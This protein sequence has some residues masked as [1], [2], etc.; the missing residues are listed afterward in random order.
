MDFQTCQQE[1]KKH[2]RMCLDLN[3]VVE[4]LQADLEVAQGSMVSTQNSL[5]SDRQRDLERE[6]ARLKAD[7]KR[8][9]ELGGSQGSSSRWPNAEDARVSVLLLYLLLDT[10]SFIRPR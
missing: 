9:R 10:M 1:L 2:K 4:S 7:L 5:G 8:E 3:K 6:V